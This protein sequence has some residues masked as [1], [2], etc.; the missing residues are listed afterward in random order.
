M[1]R[2]Q[3]DL[4]D[5]QFLLF[6][7]LRLGELLNKEPFTNWGEEEVKMV[8][9][10]AYRFAREVTGPLNASAD[11]EGC[12]LENGAVR[13]PKG[14]KEA[15][16][17]VFEAGWRTLSVPEEHGGQGAPYVVHA[18]VEEFMSGSNTAFNMYPGLC[19]GAS[20]V[21]FEFGTERQKKLFGHGMIT[22]KWGG[23]MCLTEPHAGSDVG[24]AKTSAT[25][26]ADGTYSIRGAKIFITGGDHDLAENIIHLVLARIEG[27][28][29]GTKG[30]SLFIVPKIR[31]SDDGKLGE[32]NNVTVAAIEHKM[33]INGSA[34]C[35][36]NFGENGTCIG[37]VVGNVEHQGMKQMFKMMNFARIGVG[38]QGLG[39]MSSAYL[40]AL[41]YAKERK[42]GS[43]VKAWKDPVAPRVAILEHPNVRKDLL[44]MKGIVEGMRA[45]IFTLA[46][47][48]DRA[49]AL[50][51]KNDELAA[52]HIGQVDLLTP[53]VK[54]YG[55]D[56]AYDVCTR[57]ISVFGG[58]GYLK[59]WPVEQYARDAKIFAVYEGTS[60]IQAM[61]LVGRKLGQGGGRNAQ[62]FLEDI[63]KFVAAHREHASLGKATAHLGKGQEALAGAAM[64]F[65]GWFHAGEVER[66]PLAAELFLE[67]LGDL[68]IG[69]LL[70]EAAAVA[71]REL[72]KHAEGSR[73]HG[74][75]SGKIHS[76]V[77]FAEH[78]LSLIPAKA[79]VLAAGDKSATSIPDS[80]FAAV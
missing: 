30:L 78:V 73:D 19:Q 7:Q 69:W 60:A 23:T 45:L 53:V 54:S 8:L 64:Q 62:A 38:I 65:L 74:F 61:D 21:V 3:A 4:R 24:S 28:G 18:A 29:P 6:E 31:V 40:N 16:N 76:A 49:K 44:W 11:R 15:W 5:V 34:T 41:S 66:I 1:N 39:I 35:Q 36:L 12:T 17:K 10:E 57:A 75:Y 52:Y 20:E 72:P 13:T 25:K 79:A 77:F 9:D 48:Q 22:G 80:G 46:Q 51:G 32:S 14:F 56:K 42:Q 50:A 71:D 63:A 59:D 37:E 33:G 26:N 2:Y 47:H 27:A 43:S 68:A 55:A 58:A 67:V 70:L